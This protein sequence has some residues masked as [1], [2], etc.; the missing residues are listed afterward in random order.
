MQAYGSAPWATCSQ[1]RRSQAAQ[2]AVSPSGY[3][4]AF[5]S[6]ALPSPT[7]PGVGAHKSRLTARR[8]GGGMAGADGA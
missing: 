1:T 5:N 6:T 4:S 8:G 7:W 3:K 2:L